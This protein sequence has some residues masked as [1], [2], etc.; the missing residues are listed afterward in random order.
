MLKL[1]SL[2]TTAALAACASVGFAAGPSGVY[3]FG[4]SLSDSGNDAHFVGANPG[5]IV[6]GNSYIPD[7]PYASLQFSNGS[8]WAKTFTHS[9]GFDAAGRPSWLGGGDFAFG[10][11]R[12]A[13]DGAGLPPSLTAQAGMFL[14]S[15]GG[16]AAAK[17]LYI[18]E[19]GGNDA[20][21]ALVVAAGAADPGA[22]IAAA[23]AAYA[24]SIGNIVD[25]L[26]AAGARQFIV[27]DVP[28]LG[29]APAVTA[30]GAGAAYLGSQLSQAMNGALSYRLSFEAGA[31]IFDAYG[32]LDAVAADPLKY[33][34][35]NI[36]DACAAIAGCNPSKYLFWDGIHPTSAG[37]E[38]LAQG[39]LSAAAVPEPES[40]AL[41]LAGLLVIGVRVSR[42]VA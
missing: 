3:I 2:L 38:L 28:N 9:L 7:Q 5:Q 1:K 41:L 14:G 25:Q 4:D 34:L 23:A 11:A 27:W 36:S 18:I 35:S 26:Q 6:T 20:R 12:V 42:P 17:A 32:L 24:Q 30:Q 29:L 19:G 22:V 39:M 37:H 21:D 15:T 8:V 31:S 16:V 33:G 40:C 10:G 13:T